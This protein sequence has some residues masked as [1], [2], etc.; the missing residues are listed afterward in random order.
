MVRIIVGPTKVPYQLH[1][2]LL[3]RSSSYF[4]EVLGGA[5]KGWNTALDLPEDDPELFSIIV[6]WLYAR[7]I[8]LE[9]PPP[10][11][12]CI[13]TLFRL[14]ILAE[15][16]RVLGMESA[17]LTC[18]RENCSLD[19]RAPNTTEIEYVYKHS[20]ANSPL[21]ALIADTAA[22]T[23]QKSMKDVEDYRQSIEGVPGFAIDFSKA[24]QKAARLGY[25]VMYDRRPNETVEECNARLSEQTVEE[26]NRVSIQRTNSTAA[27]T[28]LL[29]PQ[30][31]KD[32]KLVSIGAGKHV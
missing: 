27:L 13:R 17:I 14:H 23:V 22:S 26:K 20:A 8:N 30:A 10:V 4:D 11:E 15:S 12:G 18:F 31:P 5:W 25:E 1:C 2:N 6:H 32:I 3:R 21:P 24:M 9:L 16:L 7:P 28:I 29:E 19:D